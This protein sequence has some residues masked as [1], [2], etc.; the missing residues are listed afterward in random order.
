MSKTKEDTSKK[1]PAKIM[2]SWP[3][4]TISTSVSAVLIG[5]AT[6]YATD[7][8]GLSAV[9]VGFIFMLSK[10]FDGFTDIVAGYFIDKTHSKMGKGRPWQLAIIGY[11]ISIVLMFSAPEMGITASCVYLF[12]TYSMINSV[13]MTLISCSDPVYLSNALDDSR[14]SVSIL[15]FAGFISLIFT[16]AASI[17][18]PQMIKTMGTTREGWIR[19]SLILAVPF[20][21]LS[22]VRIFVIKEKRSVGK[23]SAEKITLKDMI[24]LLFSNKYILIFALI[25]LISNVG[26]SSYTTV[27][28]YFYTWILGDIG[29]GSIMSLSMLPIILV[30]MIMPVLSKKFG[31][32]RVIRITTLIGMIGYLIRL[33]NIRNVPLLFVSNVISMMGFYTM[34]AFAATFV[35]DCIDYGEWK[36]GIRS[37]GSISCAQSVTSKIGAAVGAGMIGLF[38]GFS[39]Y[40]GSAAVQTASANTMIVVLYSVVPALFCLIQFILLKAYDLDKLLPQ[41]RVDLDEK[42][43]KTQE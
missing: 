39:G 24:K 18:L 38:M 16:M 28:T 13:F 14:Q 2:L 22:L 1:I 36:N 4:M 10:I 20:T 17:I 37:E 35:I 40:E 29:I 6:Y 25:I 34:F 9:T 11:W 19:L 12:V 32:L 5:Y 31:F 23:A 3:T 21:L 8:M 33:V 42:R 15:A 41:I 30:V 7:I 26:S 27:Q 43:K